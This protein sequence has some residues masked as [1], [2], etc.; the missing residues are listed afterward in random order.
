MKVLIGLDPHKASLAVATV[1]EA[2]G[3]FLECAN[4]SQDSAGLRSLEGF[5]RNVSQSGVGP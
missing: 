3:E 4:F 2:K 1:D 5:K